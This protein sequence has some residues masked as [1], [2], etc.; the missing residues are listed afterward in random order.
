MIVGL[1][2]VHRKH[3]KYGDQGQALPQYIG[4]GR[5][6]RRVVIRVQSQHAPGQGIHHIP[7]GSL[8]DYIPDKILGQGLLRLQDLVKLPQLGLRGKFAEQQQIRCL[9]KSHP[10]LAQKSPDQIH[11]VNSPVVKLAV[12]GCF[13]SVHVFKGNNI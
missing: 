12:A 9:F 2:A 5:V 3:G 6:V 8:H 1:K 11:N 7:A 13:D 4:Q 10:A